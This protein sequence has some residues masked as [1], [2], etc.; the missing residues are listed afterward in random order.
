MREAELDPSP[1][2]DDIAA[3]L[4]EWLQSRIDGTANAWPYHPR[5]NDLGKFVRKE[6]LADLVRVSAVIA[7]L[8][9]RGRLG[10]DVNVAIT[11]P[12]GRRKKLDLI[13]GEPVGEHRPPSDGGVLKARIQRPLFSLEVKAAM[14][15]H[16]K[17]S[18]RL[19]AELQSS[20]EV[21]RTLPECAAMGVLVVNIAERFTSPL[22]LPGPNRHDQP[23]ATLNLISDVLERVPVGGSG[24]DAL[25]IVPIELDNEQLVALAPNRGW[26]P[27]TNTYSASLKAVAA[28][29]EQRVAGMH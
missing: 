12:T 23:Q 5:S 7:D 18:P 15:A 8:C 17:A 3:R 28:L 11:T 16:A 6:V 29:L 14:T 21:I 22:N 13:L 27:Q 4:V 1:I 19:V 20:L 9:K 26:C 24:Y 10:C 25:A 2:Q